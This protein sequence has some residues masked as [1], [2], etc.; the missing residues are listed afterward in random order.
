MPPLDFNFENIETTEFG[1][2]KK[3][4]KPIFMSIPVSIRVQDI[5][6]DYA[7]QTWTKIQNYDDEEIEYDPS[8]QA[9]STQY[10]HLALEN[11][12]ASV[13][14]NLHVTENLMS[15]GV[16]DIVNVTC[17][18]SR[19]TDSTGRRLTAIRKVIGF[20]SLNKYVSWMEDALD[21]ADGPIIKLDPI[22]DLLIDS[23]FVHVLHPNS[24]EHIGNLIP[25][26]RQAARKNIGILQ[27]DLPFVDMNVVQNYAAEHIRAARY[28]ASIQ[29]RGWTNGID[30][31]MLRQLCVAHNL[32]IVMDNDIWNV[33][34][35]IMKFL[36]VLDR[37]R[38]GVEL[39]RQGPEQ[40]RA[41]S[42]QRIQ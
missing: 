29:T 15:G 23:K 10:V 7:E 34:G 8:N 25:F 1:I 27:T 41:T 18:F 17:Y 14:H 37:R 5:L 28:L 30:Q 42:R 39:S 38:Y 13:F 31:N 19:F 36:E 32:N 11:E 24:F 6:R 40:F 33:A 9:A 2:G 26:I 12:M 3:Q 21:L 16:D 35:D 4:E 20:K 22:F